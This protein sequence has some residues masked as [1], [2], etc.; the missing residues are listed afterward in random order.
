MDDTIILQNGSGAFLKNNGC[1]LLMKRSSKRE[2][3]PNVWSCIGGHMETY[4]LNDPI[5][6]CLREIKEETG[7][8]ED[9][10]F[11]LKLRYV[12][13]RRYKETIRQNYIYFGETDKKESVDTEEGTLHW[14]SEK[15]LLNREY[16]KTYMEM[17]KHYIDTPDPEERI[18]VGIS[19]KG[20]NKLRMSWT[21][22][23]DFE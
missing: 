19:G 12:I 7:I 17:M 11:N 4:E 21:I 10:I 5:K 16:T 14:I 2:I 23:E 3:A 22:L 15:D 8:T 6:T 1:Y 20:N 18:I 9:H 13:I